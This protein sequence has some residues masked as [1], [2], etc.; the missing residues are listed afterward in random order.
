MTE[1]LPRYHFILAGSILL[2]LIPALFINLGLMPLIA[3]EATR[4]LVAFEMQSSGDYITPTING[5]YYFNKPPLYNWILTLFFR[6]SGNYS[7][8]MVRLPAVLS[9]LV[10]GLVIFFTTRKYTGNRPAFISALVFIT[11]GRILFYDSLLGLIDLSFSLLV[12][13]NFILIYRFAT[14]KK[15]LLLFALSYLVT[16]AT[17]MMK[18]LPAIL[19]QVFTLVTALVYLKTWRKLFHPYHLAGIFLFALLTGGYYYL[20]WNTS[21]EPDF[22]ST[23]VTESTKRTFIEHGFLKTFLHLFTYPFEQVYHL[24]PWSLLFIFLFTKEFYRD[25]R[26]KPFLT[27]LSL[28]FLV[29]IPVYWISV[30]SYPRYIFMLYPVLLI[31][32]IQ[33]YYSDNIT[34]RTGKLLWTAVSILVPAAFITGTWFFFRHEFTHPERALRI[35]LLCALLL[36]PG[37]IFFLKFRE[38]R[39]EIL[40]ICLLVLRIAFNLVILPERLAGS[41][42][43]EQK[44]KA[45]EIVDVT[46]G[47]ELL[48]YPVHPVSVESIYYISTG[49]NEI[50]QLAK[51]P[52]KKGTYYLFDNR[53]PLRDGEEVVL[54]FRSRWKG[55]EVRLSVFE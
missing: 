48:L 30:D 17:F 12:F 55:R 6:L 38:Y 22:F 47:H 25:I 11:A 15:Y 23:L 1:T 41:L 3:D 40:I 14:R 28:V 31:L 50:L 2:L 33:F 4:A 39:F 7:E 26:S 53:D 10:F 9:L 18:G 27:Y 35:Y 45:V 21:K 29:N 44:A 43:Q 37:S 34:K 19:F 49:R 24:L 32:L 54:T 13:L 52:A 20:L 8:W 51:G 42:H 46:R 16:S 36:V 5:A